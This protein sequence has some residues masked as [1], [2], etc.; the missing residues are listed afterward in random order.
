MRRLFFAAIMFASVATG[1]QAAPADDAMQVIN[2]WA[3]AFAA[4]DPARAAALFAPDALFLGTA[5][6]EV[7]AT[8]EGVRAY[9]DGALRDG[10]RSFALRQQNTL[11]VSDTLVIISGLDRMA[12]AQGMPISEGRISIVV[13]KRGA[14]WKILNFHRSVVPG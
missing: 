2:K 1:A 13:G 9:F 11:V 14:E 6:K 5:S 3:Q 12:P 4:A 10:P 8:P 7:V